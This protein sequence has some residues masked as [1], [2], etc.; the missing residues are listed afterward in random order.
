MTRIAVMNV[1]LAA[2]LAAG[3]NCRQP[4]LLVPSRLRYMNNM[5][6]TRCEF[7]GGALAAGLVPS[8]RGAEQQADLASFQREIDDIT[9]MEW[10]N[11]SLKG[12]S[13][14]EK[15][16]AA[17]RARLP[18]LQRYEDAF[19]KV[20]AEIESV[21]V[22]GRPAVWFIYN[23]GFV[24]KT[25]KSLF[26]IDLHHRRAELL[27]PKLDFALITHNHGD[28]YT[29]RFY[30]AM[31]GREKKTVVSN[32]ADNYGARYGGRHPGGYTR[33]VKTFEFGDV[34]V[35]TTLTDHNDYLIDYTTAFEIT[36]GD[37]VIYHSGDCSNAKKLKPVCQNPDLW[38]FHPWSCMKP[39]DGARAVNPKLA[40]VAHLNE[41]GHPKNQWRFTW[42]EGESVRQNLEKAGFK[43]TVPLWGDR[44]C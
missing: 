36:V 3:A 37:F 25:A 42:A 9:P 35:R 18:A 8:M 21:K 34:K 14:G 11:Y 22:T 4:V 16:G 6:V 29:D 19:D 44:I 30:R 5:K 1:A 20:L 40:V 13:L 15:E 10:W 27:A 17:I 31:D 28:H 43:A 24:V 2:M 32:F 26:A 12:T 39:L 41:L 23:M 38:M 33:A 7:I